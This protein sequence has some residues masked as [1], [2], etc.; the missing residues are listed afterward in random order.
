MGFGYNGG[1]VNITA[2][3]ALVIN[4]AINTAGTQNG[5]AIT[6]S[7]TG[8]IAVGDLLTNGGTLGGSGNGGSISI[9]SGVGSI[10]AGN[11]LTTGSSNSGN[12]TLQATNVGADV[13]FASI[14]TSAPTAGGAGG[15]VNVTAGRFVRGT[16]FTSSNPTA[17]I[18]AAADSSGA[19]TIRHGGGAVNQPFTVGDATTNGTAGAIVSGTLT[20]PNAINPPR[21]FTQS[22][23]QGNIQILTTTAPANHPK[24]PPED[25]TNI[26]T[27]SDDDLTLEAP[28][29]TPN[30][31]SEPVSE[32]ADMDKDTTTEF[33]A[34]LNLPDTVPN[35]APDTVSI[36][37]QIGDEAGVKPALVYASFV[38]PN[39]ATRDGLQ[40]IASR[41]I[42][43]AAIKSLTPG[44]SPLA[45][46]SLDPRWSR[47]AGGRSGAI[48]LDRSPD[49]PSSRRAQL[50]KEPLAN[51]ND[52]L[53]LVVVTADG[54]P[55][56]RLVP[57]ATRGRVLRSVHQFL[58]EITDPRKTRTT[59]YLAPAQQ[60]Y[61]W[62]VA[63]IEPELKAKGIS[64]LAYISDTGLRFLPMGALHDGHQFLIE[65]YSVGLMPSL[66]LTD[67]RYVSLKNAKVLA[68]GASEFRNQPPLPAVPTELSVITKNLWPG[69]AFLN[70]A[71]TLSNLKAERQQEPFQIIHLATHGEFQSG[72]LGN[73]YIQLWDTKL[74]L[75]QLR[76][77][78]WNNP[79]VELLVLSACRTAL[80]NDE[81][82]LGFAGFAVQAG[83]K[84]A[85]ASLWYVNDEG[86]LGLMTEFY[87]QLRTAPIKAEALRQAQIALL[88]GTVLIDNG[89]LRDAQGD[90]IPLPSPLA[91]DTGTYNL[92]H[93][94]YWAAF[95]LIGS[96]W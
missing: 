51:D 63:P 46:K 2:G 54:K 58:N 44:T 74:R 49:A 20:T 40:A 91:S 72:A 52:Q 60:L 13:A 34:Y 75:D 42:E 68:M 47:T 4:N 9:A 23:A 22:F 71:F 53:E 95:T 67:T 87:H 26:L 81:A 78:G 8:N 27:T 92:S 12:V 50:P 69:T 36:L 61:Q 38:P 77:L 79:P 56:R 11:L 45:A 24:L 66:S 85:L 88:R 31:F 19:I 96:P 62:L 73:S 43:G 3:G 25:P 41:E 5:G 28:T 57:G 70:Q 32:T 76:Q 33:E 6:L 29:V 64:N 35:P 14:D 90:T 39:V 17:T 21:S 18:T 7:A 93:P 37:T 65:K 83:V 80:G 89:T 10:A 59:S 1:S 84:S 55:V 94:Y 16:S 86:T 15:L 30:S 82:E 48:A